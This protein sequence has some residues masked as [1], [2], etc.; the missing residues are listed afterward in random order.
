M[1]ETGGGVWLSES[2]QE[3]HVGGDRLGGVWKP[4]DSSLLRYDVGIM[5]NGCMLE[6]Q[7]RVLGLVVGVGFHNVS[8][9]TA[10]ATAASVWAWIDGGKAWLEKVSLRRPA[11]LMQI[12]VLPIGKFMAKTLPNKDF[13]LL[14]FK[15]NLNP[16]PFNMKE[17]VVITI[18]ANCGVSSGGGLF[19]LFI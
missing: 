1:G 9:A 19:W 4:E 17:H 13:N 14:G 15:F 16:G 7:N 3:P 5:T 18:F 12:A 11:I 8:T 6:V 10:T 2:F